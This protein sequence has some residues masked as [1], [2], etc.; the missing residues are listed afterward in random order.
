MFYLRILTGKTHPQKNLKHLQ[1]KNEYG[2]LGDR[3]INS[4]LRNVVKWS[5]AL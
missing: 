3:Y 2:H 5:D 4:L 1:K